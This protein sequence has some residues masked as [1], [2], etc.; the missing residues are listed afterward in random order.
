VVTP[1]SPLGRALTGARA[2][3]E[4][5]WAAPE[6]RLWAGVGDVEPDHAPTLTEAAAGSEEERTWPRSRQ[7]GAAG[8]G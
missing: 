3:E 8:C 6:G 1:D 7:S 4:I 2:G 5:T